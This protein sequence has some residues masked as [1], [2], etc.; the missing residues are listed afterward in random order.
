MK[1]RMPLE[2]KALIVMAV[3]LCVYVIVYIWT[4]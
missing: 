3:A 1:M 4:H 2:W